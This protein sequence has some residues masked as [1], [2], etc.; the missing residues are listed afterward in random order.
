MATGSK[1]VPPHLRLSKKLR[2]GDIATQCPKC[3]AQCEKFRGSLGAEPAF[4]ACVKWPTCT[5]RLSVA[6]VTFWQS[7]IAKSEAKARK[8]KEKRGERI[9]I[10]KQ[11]AARKRAAAAAREVR[12]E[13]DI[14]KNIA[15][16]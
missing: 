9:K 5:G 16:F 3:G 10:G 7:R 11:R 4:Y 14:E 13:K 15:P 2:T 6:Q 1:I 12:I 8:K